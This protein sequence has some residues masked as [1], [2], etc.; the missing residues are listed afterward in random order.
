[1]FPHLGTAIAGPGS[2]VAGGLHRRGEA[3][4]GFSSGKPKD[5]VS[6]TRAIDFRKI[7]LL[8]IRA[9]PRRAKELTMS[10]K[11]HAVRSVFD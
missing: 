2:C 8:D 7:E 10:S 3:V 6:M 11:L 9:L 5:L 4:R 1:M